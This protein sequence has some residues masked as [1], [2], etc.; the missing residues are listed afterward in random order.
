M[1]SKILKFYDILDVIE[2]ILDD[3]NLVQVL[4]RSIRCQ[5]EPCAELGGG[6]RNLVAGW[7]FEIFLNFRAFFNVQAV[8]KVARYVRLFFMDL[9]GFFGVFSLIGGI[10]LAIL[11]SI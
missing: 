11:K 9:Y 4:F 8:Y 1:H 7:R 6:W 10:L 5:I 3:P 2:L